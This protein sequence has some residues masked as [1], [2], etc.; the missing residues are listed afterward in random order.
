MTAR[1]NSA[2]RG[3]RRPS[4]PSRSARADRSAAASASPNVGA[5][6]IS[7]PARPVVAATARQR[8]VGLDLHERLIQR[9]VR[10]DLPEPLDDLGLG[11]A[12]ADVREPEL[13][14]HGSA[15]HEPLRRGHDA[16][17]ARQIVVLRTLEGEYRV[18]SRHP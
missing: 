5:G 1:M 2:S 6:R 7:R 10:A 17:R 8:L 16:L 13:E 11:E 18:P 9:Y 12:L 3:P 4:P 15:L 14:R